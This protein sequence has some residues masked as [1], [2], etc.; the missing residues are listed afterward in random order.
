MTQIT[1][2]APTP[3][4]A[5]DT[6]VALPGQVPRQQPATGLRPPGGRGGPLRSGNPRGNPNLAP[7]CGA[8]AR[9]TG[10][11]CR[12]PAMAN[13]RCRMHGGKCTRPRTP[14][15]LASLAAART[16]TGDHGAASRATYRYRRAVVIR[17][18]LL[19]AAYALGA[20][21]PPDIAALMA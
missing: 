4:T 17:T 7:R 16:K 14:E 5:P 21:L 2:A 6:S 18:R 19:T 11:A 9:T 12:A 8:K 20:Y 3:A 13:G 10:L 15:G 1:A